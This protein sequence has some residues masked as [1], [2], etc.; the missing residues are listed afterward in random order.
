MNRTLLMPMMGLV[1]CTMAC[2]EKELEPEPEDTAVE[3]GDD[4][5]TEDTEETGDTEDPGA[6]D[7]DGDGV[8]DELDCDDND[9][10]MSP[11]LDEVCDGKDNDCDG[12]IPMHELDLTGDGVIDCEPVECDA[13]AMTW[14][15]AERDEDLGTVGASCHVDG[16]CDAYKGDASCSEPRE[17]LCVMNDDSPNPDGYGAWFSGES[18]LTGPIAGCQLTSSD[19]ADILCEQTFGA[20]YRMAEFH[21]GGGWSFWSYGEWETDERFM[22]AISNKPANCW[23]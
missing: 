18:A 19:A 13:K 7:N 23:N 14:G 3:Q 5:E 2:G 20:G 21:D 11:L 4:T 17:V 9:P 22:V 6:V 15:M 8:T 10:E 12:E 16:S 1:L